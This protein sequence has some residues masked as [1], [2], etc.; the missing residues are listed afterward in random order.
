[1]YMYILGEGG[2]AMMHMYIVTIER[3]LCIDIYV[4]M[5]G[6]DHASHALQLLSDTCNYSVLHVYIY[7][8][9]VYDKT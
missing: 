6:F 9:E 7:V 4:R 5:L 1:M 3:M 2:L 8:A